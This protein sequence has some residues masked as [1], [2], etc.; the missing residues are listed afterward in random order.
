MTISRLLHTETGP[1]HHIHKGG[2][3]ANSTQVADCAQLPQT[4][5]NTQ[6]QNVRCKLEKH[7]QSG[8]DYKELI[9]H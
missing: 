8:L 6:G 7:L 3:T 5:S 1:K 9:N 4:P 2:T